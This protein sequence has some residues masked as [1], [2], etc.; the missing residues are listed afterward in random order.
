MI[1]VGVPRALLYY[2]YFPMWRAFLEALGAEV[3]VSSPTTKQE[4]A[5]GSA[6][7]V[8]ETCLPVKVFCGHVHSLI[9]LC[10]YL[11]IPSIRS[12]GPGEFNCSKFLG[13]PDMM[14]AAVPQ[15]P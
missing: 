4:V 12:V 2:Q 11:F 14:R 6:C 8:A 7:L 3:V 13:L 5:K 10:D 1:R 15:A 9:G